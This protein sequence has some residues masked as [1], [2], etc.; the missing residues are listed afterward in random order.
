MAALH[1]PVDQL[2]S[3]LDDRRHLDRR[4]APVHREPQITQPRT[5]RRRHE[6]EHHR[7]GGDQWCHG[8]YS[9]PHSGQIIAGHGSRGTTVAGCSTAAQLARCRTRHRQRCSPTVGSPSE[10]GH[11]FA[12]L[13]VAAA[14]HLDLGRGVLDLGELVRRQLD[15]GGAEVL[16]QPVQPCGCRGSGRSTASGPGARPGRSGRGWRPC[17]RRSPTS[18]STTAWLCCSASGS[19]RG[20][21]LR[22]S[23]PASKL[24]DAVMVP[25]RK[26][27]PSGLYGTKPMPSSSH[28]ASTS[29]SGRRHH[30][31]YSLCTAVT[32]WTACAR[33]IVAAAASDMPKCLTLPASMSSLTAPA[34]SSMG[35]SGL[36]RCW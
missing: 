1:E 25:V 12:G 19:N 4:A 6:P 3:G 23:L 15:V 29:S 13:A 22:M 26:P 18:R 8:R 16:L 21:V 31:E 35:T 10:V 32:G 24:V 9:R 5:I 33:R 27:L 36:T 14:L 11:P 7:R 17:A 20:M 2:V 28:A 34:T 30:S